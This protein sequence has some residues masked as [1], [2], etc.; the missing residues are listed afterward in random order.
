MLNVA[1]R[2][3]VTPD[4]HQ[5]EARR[6]VELARLGRSGVGLAVLFA[7]FELALSSRWLSGGRAGEGLGGLGRRNRTPDNYACQMGY[8]CSSYSLFSATLSSDP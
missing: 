7:L 2:L 3:I 4:R 6:V 1:N 8:F 5:A